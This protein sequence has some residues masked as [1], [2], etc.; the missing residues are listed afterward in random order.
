MVFVEMLI[1]GVIAMVVASC[2]IGVS[3][4]INNR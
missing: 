4:Y 3:N 1:I 2:L